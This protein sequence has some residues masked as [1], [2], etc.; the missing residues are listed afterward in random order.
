MKRMIGVLL[1][2]L[3]L[4][5]GTKLLASALLPGRTVGLG[6]L[7]ELRLTRNDGMALGL[8]AGNRAAGMLLPLAV[9]ALGW[10][11]LRR[12]RLTPF[13]QTACGLVLGGFLGNFLERLWHGW[14][15]DMIYFPFL[16]WFVCNVADIAICAGVALMAASLLFRP[17]DWKEA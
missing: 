6:W 13:T 2:T 17:Q 8:F 12:Y 11:L 15:L 10:L 5:A 4:D 7:V 14:V 3:A 1:A 9:I 16:P